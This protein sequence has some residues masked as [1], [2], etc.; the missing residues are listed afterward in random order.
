MTAK[1]KEHHRDWG[2][3]DVSARAWEAC[4]RAVCLE[5]KLADALMKALQM[6]LPAQDWAGQCFIR[7]GGRAHEVAPPNSG[8]MDN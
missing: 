6:W 2:Q 8:A 7:E 5:H 4:S 3:R 1:L